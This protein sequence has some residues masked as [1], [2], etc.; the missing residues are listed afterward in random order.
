MKTLIFLKKICKKIN[1]PGIFIGLTFFSFTLIACLI[2]NSGAVFAANNKKLPGKKLSQKK[3][4]AIH[5]TSDTMISERNTG[6]IEFSG[7]ACA[8]DGESVIK[9][10]FIKIFLYKQNEHPPIG[11]KKQNI[12][13]IIALGNVRYTSGNKKA[14]SDKAVYTTKNQIIVLT[15]KA[16]TVTMGAS[17]VTG[18][19]ITLFQK[20]SRVM[21]ESG[22]QRRV[23]ALFNSKDRIK[24]TK[25]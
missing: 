22:K 18:K 7:N 9:A 14:F 23:Q 2:V 13:K 15:G 6:F 16:P 20:D 5:V 12:K 8:T 25:K 21:V 17:F 11:E 3:P 19:K 10:D 1:W 24:K 4:D